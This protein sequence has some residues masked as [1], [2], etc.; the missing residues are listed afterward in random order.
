MSVGIPAGRLLVV[1]YAER[2]GRTRI[3]GAR[4]ASPKGAEAVCIRKRTLGPTTTFARNTTS[5]RAFV[6]GI[7][8]YRGTNIVF[9]EPDVARVFTDSASVNQA[10]RLL[11]RLARDQIPSE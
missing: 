8:T 7:Q 11:L 9:L 3:I 1:A 4:M 10:I 5:P 2:T 6:G